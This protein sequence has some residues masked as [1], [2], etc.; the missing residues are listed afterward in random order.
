M[1][2]TVWL[3]VYSRVSE[4]AEASL[5]FPLDGVDGYSSCSLGFE[6]HAN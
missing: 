3:V 2:V 6:S 1:I 5:V 4:E